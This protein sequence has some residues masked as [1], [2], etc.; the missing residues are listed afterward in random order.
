MR[1]MALVP[2]ERKTR[3]D[4]RCISVRSRYNLPVAISTALCSRSVTMRSM[5]ALRSGTLGFSRMVKA[6]TNQWLPRSF[7]EASAEGGLG[8]DSVAARGVGS[9]ETAGIWKSAAGL[10]KKR[11]VIVPACLWV[12]PFFWERWALGPLDCRGAKRHLAMTDFGLELE[13]HPTRWNHPSDGDA[14]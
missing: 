10:R 2:G 6:K 4:R 3:G 5:S 1:T 12:D 14:R 9:G 8:A 13:H 11:A 7:S